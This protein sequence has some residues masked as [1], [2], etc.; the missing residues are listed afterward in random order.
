ML[1]RVAIYQSGVTEAGSYRSGFNTGHPETV[2]CRQCGAVVAAR[3]VS[4]GRQHRQL[5]QFFSPIKSVSSFSPFSSFSF[6][7]LVSSV[8]SVSPDSLTESYPVSI[9]PKPLMS[10]CLAP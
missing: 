10:V 6:V 5:L 4:A 9:M 8:S 1:F 3:C 2:P 7:T